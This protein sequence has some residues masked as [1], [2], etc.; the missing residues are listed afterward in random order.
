VDRVAT[1]PKRKRG[2]IDS[3]RCYP[4]VPRLRFGLVVYRSSSRS[5][6]VSH[7]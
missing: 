2:R 5:D 3:T 7:E 1:S 4:N 6:F